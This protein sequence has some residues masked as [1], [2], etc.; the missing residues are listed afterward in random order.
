MDPSAIVCLALW[1]IIAIKVSVR[2]VN[3]NSRNSSVIYILIVCLFVSLGDD[4]C[5]ELKNCFTNCDFGY[6]RDKNNCELCECNCVNEEN[7]FEAIKNAFLSS[8]QNK[9]QFCKRPCKLG[10]YKDEYNCFKCECLEDYLPKPDLM[11]TTIAT[12]ISSMSDEFCSVI[13]F[14]FFFDN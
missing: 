10:Y 1:A 4:N 6:K 7:Y 3:R 9:S 2:N 14:F 13:I 11:L 12:P 8:Q 5:P